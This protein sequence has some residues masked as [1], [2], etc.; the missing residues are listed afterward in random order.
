MA[1]LNNAT[2]T[3]IKEAMM[4]EFRGVDH[5]QTLET[6]LQT[7][8]FARESDIPLFSLE[9]KTLIK[10]LYSIENDKTIELIASNHIVADLEPSFR[11]NV[12]ILQLCGNTRLESLLELIK[13]KLDIELC[14]IGT[15]ITV[16]FPA[17]STDS[18]RLDKLENMVEIYTEQVDNLETTKLGEGN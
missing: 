14:N 18:D 9:L 15:K 7:I 17:K 11:E 2:F 5:K 12:K 1:L 4:K 16:P 3:D 10:E 6:K 13:S 8:K